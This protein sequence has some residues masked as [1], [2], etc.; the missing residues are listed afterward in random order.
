MH[1]KTFDRIYIRK[2]FFET[3]LNKMLLEMSELDYKNLNQYDKGGYDGYNQAVT[4]L[5][6]KLQT[7]FSKAN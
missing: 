2:D 1:P 5:L 7:K 6:K 4:E 3:E